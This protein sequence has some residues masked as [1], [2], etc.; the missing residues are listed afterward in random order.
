MKGDALAKISSVSST[1]LPC[2]QAGFSVFITDSHQEPEHFSCVSTSS[3]SADDEK[4]ACSQ[5]KAKLEKIERVAKMNGSAAPCEQHEHPSSC[6][7]S[8][9]L[10]ILDER[11]SRYKANAIDSSSTLLRN[12]FN[13]SA[14]LSDAQ[15]QELLRLLG[16]FENLFVNDVSEL[17]PADLPPY[18]IDTADSKPFFCPPARATPKQQADINKLVKEMLEAQIISPSESPWSSRIVLVEKRDGGPPRLCVDYRQLNKR[19][20]KDRFPL[21]R[22][23]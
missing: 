12:D 22:I 11:L 3:D 8:K 20:V 23:D 18:H 4:N 5:S 15:Q 16:R 6:D 13:V 1:P 19:M 14:T 17:S 2:E 21:P 9:F 10:K 7:D